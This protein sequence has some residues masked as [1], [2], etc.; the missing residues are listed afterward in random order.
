MPFFPGEIF[1][2]KKQLIFQKTKKNARNT[3]FR[4]LLLE[5]LLFS[6]RIA[7]VPLYT[8]VS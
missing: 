6:L 8:M 4:R 5:Q 3:R 2:Y 7:S 1:L